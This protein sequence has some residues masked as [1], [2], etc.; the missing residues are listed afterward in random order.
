MR[1]ITKITITSPESST[2][3]TAKIKT[4]TTD[5]K[6]MAAR[7]SNWIDGIRAGST[8]GSIDLQI[9]EG[10]A[11]AASGTLTFTSVV[12]DNTLA[13]NGTTFTART[14]PSTSVQFGVGADDN[15]T[16]T[17]AIAKIN[18]HAVGG[19]VVASDGSTKASGTLTLSGCVEDDTAVINGVTF[20]CKNAPTGNVLYFKKGADDNATA[21]NLVNV[22]NSSSNA[23]ITG[24][25]TATLSGTAEVTITAVARGLS[26]N[27]ITLVG[28]A[29]LTASGAT[30]SGGDAILTITAKYKGILGNAITLAGTTDKITAS[31]A[32]L[33][34]G[35]EATAI[36]YAF[37]A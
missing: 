4:S 35:A 24:I 7:L 6:G 36:T 22:I 17:N 30:L 3:L 2:D 27:A 25:L 12:Q 26:G 19:Y 8:S 14:S 16:V 34:S 32:R 5:P 29:H 1:T 31:A 37:G 13:I 18:A 11:V 23:L 20:T 21:Q 15:A 28:G 9:G 10:D 33:A